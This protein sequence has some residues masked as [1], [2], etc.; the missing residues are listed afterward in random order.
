M[1][2][3]VHEN[4]VRRLAVSIKYAGCGIVN[5]KGETAGF[6]LA[7]AH[8]KP[9]CDDRIFGASTMEDRPSQGKTIH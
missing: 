2:L 3:M 7:V 5:V 8:G 4:V 6:W 9:G 1:Y